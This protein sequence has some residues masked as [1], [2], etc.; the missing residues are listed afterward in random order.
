MRGGIVTGKLKE[1]GRCHGGGDC[2]RFFRSVVSIY[3]SCLPFGQSIA[4]PSLTTL[5]H[6][7]DRHSS[8]HLQASILRVGHVG[9]SI[10]F[11][12]LWVCLIRTREVFEAL[13]DPSNFER[14]KT[15]IRILMVEPL[16]V[17]S[18]YISFWCLLHLSSIS[19]TRRFHLDLSFVYYFALSPTSGNDAAMNTTG[20]CILG[21]RSP[22]SH[23]VKLKFYRLY[24]LK[25][26]QVPSPSSLESAVV[27]LPFGGSQ[28]VIK[29]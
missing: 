23:A 29:S 22:N 13:A 11:G 2:H 19:V 27:G 6:S 26:L 3:R 12:G 18:K 17:C 4:G 25:N 1:V 28:F 16:P 15:H 20:P 10:N 24:N 7:H 14:V 8:C 9:M 21:Q 5:L